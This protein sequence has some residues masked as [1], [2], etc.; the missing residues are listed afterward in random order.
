MN[1][2]TMG[3]GPLLAERLFAPSNESVPARTSHSFA[4][5]SSRQRD[6]NLVK[7]IINVN[8]K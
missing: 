8:W 4:V 7:V 3:I 2:F 6:V 1:P 5:P